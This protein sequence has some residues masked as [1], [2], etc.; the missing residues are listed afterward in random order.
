MSSSEAF[1]G[2]QRTSRWTEGRRDRVSIW[3]EGG[4]AHP[5]RSFG[6][7]GCPGTVPARGGVVLEGPRAWTQCGEQG[8]GS[9]QGTPPATPPGRFRAPRGSLCT[10]MSRGHAVA[11]KDGGSGLTLVLP[12]TTHVLRHPAHGAEQGR[13][14]GAG[15]LAADEV[16]QLGAPRPR[17][18]GGPGLQ[19][20][21]LG[22]EG[23]GEGRQGGA[24][25]RGG[26]KGEGK[27]A[28]GVS[29]PRRT[30]TS[31][32]RD[33]GQTCWAGFVAGTWVSSHLCDVAQWAP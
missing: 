6:V 20:L 3:P 16:L 7:R 2:N 23:L 31:T 18:P 12:G 11:L 8:P 22:F 15:H 29:P 28:P 21:D 26:G 5:G 14:V 32:A 9:S 19:V 1:L 27:G 24:R 30:P 4:R 17:P 33:S 25:W 13:Q 10:P